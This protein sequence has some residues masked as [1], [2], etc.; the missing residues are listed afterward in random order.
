MRFIAVN[1]LIFLLCTM[2]LGCQ[3]KAEIPKDERKEPVQLPEFNTI[4]TDQ[5]FVYNC[6][7]SLQFT[8]HVTSDSA[9]LFLADTSVKVLPTRSA[10][11]ARYEGGKY[12]YWSKG[13]EAILQKPKGSFMTCQSVPEE[14]SWAAAKLRGVDFRALGQEPGWFLELQNKGQLKYVGNYGQDTITVKTPT[15]DTDIQGKRTVYQAK[16]AQHVLK[17][18]IA[19]TPCTDSMSGFDFPQTV[20]VSIDGETYRGCGRYLQ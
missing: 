7:D 5:V 9:W 8:T 17:F 11:G 12:L 20:T 4:N 13:N 15:P 18:V 16:D 19:E 3:N 10:S 14:R 1:W 2:G 6:A